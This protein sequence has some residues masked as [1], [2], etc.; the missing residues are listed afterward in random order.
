M[1]KPSEICWTL[2]GIFEK[3]LSGT[4]EKALSGTFEKAKQKPLEPFEKPSFQVFNMDDERHPRKSA[5]PGIF[6]HDDAFTRT[7]ESRRFLIHFS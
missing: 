2:S 5:I 7:V 4:F 1:K 6:A 3:A